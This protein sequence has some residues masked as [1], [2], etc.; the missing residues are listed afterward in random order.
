MR[1][2]I[3]L[4]AGGIEQYWTEA[5]MKDLPDLLNRDAKKL[6]DA[7]AEEHDVVFPG[8]AGNVTDARRIGKILRDEP[9]H[10]VLMY[11][12]T[13]IDDAMS[14][15]LLDEIDGIFPVLFHS[16]GFNNFCEPMDLM[17]YGRSWGNNS[18][19]QLAGTLKRVMPGKKMGYVFGGINNPQSI[20][21]ITQYARAAK[22]VENLKGKRIGFLPHRSLGVPMYDTF[23]DE[24]IVI[25]QTGVEIDYLYIIELVE[26]MKMLPETDVLRFK[27]ELTDKCDIIE[28]SDE[29]V[30]GSCRLALALQTL[31]DQKNT[32][33]VA[34]DFS[35][36]M[37]PLTGV[38][39]CVGM[40]SL[41]DKGVIVTSE[42]DISVAVAGLIV[43]EITGTPI[44]FWEHLAFDEEKNW[45]LGGHEG[46]S[47]GFAM[48]K[49][50]TRPKLRNNQYINWDGIQGAPHHGVVP[51]FITNPGP[52][53]L[54]T[55]FRGSEG[56]EMRIASGESVDCDPLPVHYEHTVFRP[57][58]DLHTYFKRIAEVGVCHHFALVHR[59]I[60][61]E[62]VK[63]AEIMGTKIE[64]LT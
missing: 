12:A 21:E 64:H 31:V 15:A 61:G 13:Y 35:T 36:G 2:K 4:F 30:T 34:V 5:G 38:M 49:A 10:M 50:D 23:P 41:I 45:I 19:V 46:G 42:G 26:L 29:E 58:I 9:V 3:G 33:A 11:H 24:A 18:S 60:V 56:Y 53:I 43:R 22:A 57:H 8:L 39:P 20:T 55:F 17:N 44:H 7:L 16:Q 37:M 59:D 27:R 14:K 48:A 51:E 54:L 25:A 1:A 32:D 47:A 40:A 62:L 52:A 63:V 6:V 28:P